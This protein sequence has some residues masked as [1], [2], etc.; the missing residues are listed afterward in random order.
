[1]AA[2]SG[3]LA[4]IGFLAGV[5][6]HLEQVNGGW[7]KFIQPE[8]QQKLLA[9]VEDMENMKCCEACIYK[10]KSGFTYFLQTN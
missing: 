1:M 10:E 8:Q 3:I 5:G 6:F 9:L 4:G 7:I 2:D